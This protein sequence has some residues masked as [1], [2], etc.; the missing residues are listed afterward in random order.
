ML[1]LCNNT[2]ILCMQETHTTDTS[3]KAWKPPEDFTPFWSHDTRQR[4][5]VVTL[6]R[7]DF[8]KTFN[9]ILTKDIHHIEQGRLLGIN[10]QHPT[11]GN[12][13]VVN[14]YLQSGG[15]RHKER[16]QAIEKLATIIPAHIKQTTILTGDFNFV[17]HKEDRLCL[18][19]TEHTGHSDSNEARLFKST[20]LKP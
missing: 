17:E 11:M 7:N 1:K 2:D 5:G 9:P 10:L 6:I 3:V 13:Y 8:L 4:A 16:I 15:D 20:L 19:K 18:V 14:A 12:L